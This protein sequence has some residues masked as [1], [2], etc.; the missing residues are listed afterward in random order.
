MAL[1]IVGAGLPR[2]GTASLRR[3]L[4]KLLGGHCYHMSAIPGHP[5]ELG[6]DWDRVLKGQPVNWDHV[7]K[8]FTA[9]V[10]FPAS[11]FWRDLSDAYPDAPVLLSVRDSA[12]T[13]YASADATILPYAR[14]SLVADW[15]GGHHFVDLMTRFAATADWNDK[16]TLIAAY[17]RHNDAVRRSISPE[18]L[19]EWHASD[20]WEPIC[21]VLG[22]PVPDEPF[23]WTNRRS[24]WT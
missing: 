2:T 8:G 5:F 15:A 24:E 16:A 6:E 18:R 20:G 21:A 23:P 12:E 13:W 7:F 17:E 3:A 14:M 22:V 1:Q 19:L 11:L 9:A 10:D 4:E